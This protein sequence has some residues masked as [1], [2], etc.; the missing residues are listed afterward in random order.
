MLIARCE[1]SITDAVAA[2]LSHADRALAKRKKRKKALGSIEASLE[3][4][5][6]SGCAARAAK[7]SECVELGCL[8]VVDE[9]RRQCPG[10]AVAKWEGYLAADK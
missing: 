4:R 8:A 7:I 1:V 3:R 2:T 9:V 10:A 6:S 5:T